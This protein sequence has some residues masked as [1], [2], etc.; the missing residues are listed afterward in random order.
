MSF[1]YRVKSRLLRPQSSFLKDTPG[2]ISIDLST[3]AEAEDPRAQSEPGSIANEEEEE[4]VQFPLFRNVSLKKKIPPNRASTI[5]RN[6]ELD[7]GWIFGWMERIVWLTMFISV[8]WAIFYNFERATSEVCYIHGDEHYPF[9]ILPSLSRAMSSFRVGK[10]IWTAI[11]AGVF[12]ARLLSNHFLHRLYET[13]YFDNWFNK[14][15]LNVAYLLDTLEIISLVMIPAFSLDCDPGEHSVFFRVFIVLTFAAELLQYFT[16]FLK[17][18]VGIVLHSKDV[19]NYYRQIGVLIILQMVFIAC[20]VTG[21]MLHDKLCGDLMWS[22]FTVSEYVTVVINVRSEPITRLPLLKQ[23]AITSNDLLEVFS[24]QGKNFQRQKLLFRTVHGV[25]FLNF[26]ELCE[27][28]PTFTSRT[29]CIPTFPLLFALTAALNAT[30]TL[31]S[32]LTE[33][34]KQLDYNLPELYLRR[35]SSQGEPATTI[36]LLSG[37]LILFASFCYAVVQLESPAIFHLV[38][39]I[40][41]QFHSNLRNS[42]VK[43]CLTLLTCLCCMSISA[44]FE[45]GIISGLVSPEKPVVIDSLTR[46]HTVGYTTL[47]T[48]NSGE[49]D[50]VDKKFEKTATMESNYSTK[51]GGIDFRLFFFKNSVDSIANFVRT[52]GHSVKMTS[53]GAV[54][55]EGEMVPSYVNYMGRKYPN[56]TCFGVVGEHVD[57]LS[58]NGPMPNVAFRW[59]GRYRGARRVR[60]ILERFVSAGLGTFYRE[61]L[62]FR[63]KLANVEFDNGEDETKADGG[64]KSEFVTLR[65]TSQVFKVCGIFWS[66]SLV[67]FVC[68]TISLRIKMLAS[69]S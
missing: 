61:F 32:I 34:D 11:M 65:G 6:V 19:N 62:N 38:R 23:D 55:I 68:E 17:R 45:G 29:E 30:L 67:V 25:K 22:I 59:E 56:L 10:F 1:R 50:N 42:G 33:A 8:G 52:S 60:N 31:R 7:F 64:N 47:Y 24:Q 57:K 14:I 36:D 27:T 3:H 54:L 40:L 16:K 20:M 51:N 41:H 44:F 5:R 37:L 28:Y 4:V 66:I 49:M 48:G 58:G 46:L 12:V 21:Y 43:A 13:W 63:M 15:Y 26:G 69:N 18:K 9:N 53:S 2:S 35:V 39:A